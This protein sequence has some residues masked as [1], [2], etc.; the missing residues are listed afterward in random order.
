M[1][2]KKYNEY[3]VVWNKERTVIE[4]KFLTKRGHV[5]I[6]DH[7]ANLMNENTK[8][9]CLLYEPVE[10]VK[11]AIEPVRVPAETMSIDEAIEREGLFE[12]AKERGLKFPKNISTKNLRAKLAE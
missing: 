9:S 8:N 11:Q 12:Q 6:H 10:E 2:P 1:T 7:E 4:Q 3:R 5:S